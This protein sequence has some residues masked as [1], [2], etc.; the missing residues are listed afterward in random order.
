MKLKVTQTT[1]EI[2]LSRLI[3]MASNPDIQEIQL[4][5]FFS[6][7]WPHWQFEVRLLL[8]TVCTCI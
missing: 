1:V 7:N 6:E 3:G 2:H 8:F 4:S 5:G